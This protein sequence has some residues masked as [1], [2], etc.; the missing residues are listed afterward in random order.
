[1]NDHLFDGS[2]IS[3][4]AVWFTNYLAWAAQVIILGQHASA[5]DPNSYG[6][7]ASRL[8]CFSPVLLLIRFGYDQIGVTF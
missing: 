8:I 1:M 5:V 2:P 7:E 6:V 4:L 3:A